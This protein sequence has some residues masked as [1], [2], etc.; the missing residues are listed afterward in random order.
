MH[1]TSQL[2]NVSSDIIAMDHPRQV[3]ATRAK[4]TT[5][6]VSYSFSVSNYLLDLNI[7]SF[8]CG[9]RAP[10]CSSCALRGLCKRLVHVAA[11][12]HLI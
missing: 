8:A 7:P 10:L 2:H 3:R 12:L 9:H 4:E 11:L 6:S 5:S 1:A